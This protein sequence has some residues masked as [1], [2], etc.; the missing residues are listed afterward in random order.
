MKISE[1][2]QLTGMTVPTIRYYDELGLLCLLKRNAQHQRTFTNED[3]QWLFRLKKL[4]A[5]GLTLKTLAA[6]ICVLDQ[7]NKIEKR[8]QIL[9]A[10]KKKIK[11]EIK[12]LQEALNVIDQE[13]ATPTFFD[14][15]E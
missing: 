14:E 6:Y 13:I 2:S 5:S 15:I 1:V 12:Q 7:E 4:H 3:V 9:L 10:Q 11:S 8:E